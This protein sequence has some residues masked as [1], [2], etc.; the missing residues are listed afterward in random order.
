[1]GAEQ[2]E[3]CTHYYKLAPFLLKAVCIVFILQCTWGKLCTIATELQLKIVA[4][5]ILAANM[6]AMLCDLKKIVN[7]KK[8]ENTTN[9]L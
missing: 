9:V 1:M 7:R 3:G 4:A 8:R 6:S 5:D 2:E